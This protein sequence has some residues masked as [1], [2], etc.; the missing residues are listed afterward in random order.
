MVK[1]ADGLY[2]QRRA[3]DL[4]EGHLD[5]D[6]WAGAGE[7]RRWRPPNISNLSRGRGKLGP[8]PLKNIFL[9]VAGPTGPDGAP[10][11]FCCGLRIVSMD[12][13][14]SG[15]PESKANDEFFGRPSS[16]ARNGAFAQVRWIVAA[17]SGTGSLL[18]GGAWPLSHVRAGTSP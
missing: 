11:V 1:L 10:G 3:A 5:P 13:S 16:Q 4:L 2:H 15:V 8:E 18:G 17:E 9:Q 12:G 6:G 7:G 14:T